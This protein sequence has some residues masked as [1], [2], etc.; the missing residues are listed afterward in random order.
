MTI[1][2]ANQVWA[3]DTT[4]IP[5]AKGF[6]HLTGVVDWATRK[7]LAAKMAIT[8]EACHAVEVQEQVFIR[9]D[10]SAPTNRSFSNFR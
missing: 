6:A 9:L 10:A 3:L 5:L 1:R 4:Y 8:L 2:R 7:V